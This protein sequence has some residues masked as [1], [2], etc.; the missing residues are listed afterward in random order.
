MKKCLK[1]RGEFELRFE[2]LV[3][4]SNCKGLVRRIKLNFGRIM[5]LKVRFLKSYGLPK[6]D[7]AQG[8]GNRFCARKFADAAIEDC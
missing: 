7:Q 1:M 6:L 5:R 8:Q 2:L 3:L 4:T